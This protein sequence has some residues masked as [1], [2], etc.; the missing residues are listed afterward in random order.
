MKKTGM[1]KTGIVRV[2]LVVALMAFSGA[3][4]EEER[5]GADWQTL[6]EVAETERP[7][8]GVSSAD[9]ARELALQTL[10]RRGHGMR[11]EEGLQCRGVLV[12]GFDV[13]GFAQTGDR[14]WEVR[15]MDVEGRLMA[16]LWVHADSGKVHFACDSRVRA[17]TAVE[18]SVRMA[19][20]EFGEGEPVGFVLRLDNATGADEA[21]SLGGGLDSLRIE[22]SDSRR[23]F[24]LAL[25]L[26][27]GGLTPLVRPVP[28]PE[29]PYLQGI[30][31]DDFTGF[32][33]EPGKYR[34]TVS[35]MPDPWPEK[36]PE[37]TRWALPAPATAEFRVAEEAP[38]V[39]E[40]VKRRLA[41]WLEL[42]AGGGGE[43]WPSWMARKAVLI[44]RN[45]AAWEVQEEWLR[46]GTWSGPEE[47]QWLSESLLASGREG[48]VE[49]L[50]AHVLE[51]P[52]CGRSERGVVLYALKKRG[53]PEGEDGRARLLEPWR[54]E[55]LQAGPFCVSD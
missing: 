26:E 21:V 20:E 31:L 13:E 33:L 29:R 6:Q 10:V 50:V 52:R 28:S 17:G 1:G 5:N 4:G 22:L 51:N 48:V 49:L 40:A 8:C 46:E 36:P 37:G 30:F 54:E 16:I 23:T 9:E 32:G 55:L 15:A 44:S 3:V 2:C 18:M 35:V 41:H 53:V 11:A 43:E 19:S 12:L 47:L 34:M 27:P 25:P 7:G 39:R 45:P 14:V 24:R 38:R 42:A